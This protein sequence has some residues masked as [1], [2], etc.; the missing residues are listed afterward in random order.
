MLIRQPVYPPGMY[1]CV[2]GFV[3]PGESLAECVTREC[4]EEAG[5]EV[6]PQSLHLVDS[7]HWPNPAGSLMMGCIVTSETE[8]PSPCSHEIEEVRWFSPQELCQ[9]V[10]VSQENPGLRFAKNHDPGI[11]F[12]PPKGAIANVIIRDWLLR[13][14]NLTC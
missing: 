6:D 14:H 10:Q 5:V 2:A 7:N 11:L 13:Y 3:D 8:N 1:S 4:A 12:V 9:A